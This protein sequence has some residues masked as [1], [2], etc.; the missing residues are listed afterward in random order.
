MSGL[1]EQTVNGQVALSNVLESKVSWVPCISDFMSSI[2]LSFLLNSVIELSWLP[3][4]SIIY[5]T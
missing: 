3:A 2:Y 5:P 4:A 1:Y